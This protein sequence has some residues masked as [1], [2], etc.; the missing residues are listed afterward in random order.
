MSKLLTNQYITGD[1]DWIVV[2]LSSKSEISAAGW[3]GQSAEFENIK[4]W[5]RAT[6]SGT[7]AYSSNL[8]I[9]YDDK[10]GFM[11]SDGYF[12]FKDEQDVLAIAFFS[13]NIYIN[14]MWSAKTKFTV[15]DRD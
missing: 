5:L 11:V 4:K 3:V 9:R 6:C 15:F 7:Y 1:S 13:N 14:P 2:K 10:L 8:D 12:A